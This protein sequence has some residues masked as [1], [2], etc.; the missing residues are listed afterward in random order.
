VTDVKAQ[1]IAALQCAMQAAALQRAEHARAIHRQ[2][3]VLPLRSF[4][5]PD[6]SDGVGE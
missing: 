4:Q 1:V 6:C 5:R 2:R 3:G